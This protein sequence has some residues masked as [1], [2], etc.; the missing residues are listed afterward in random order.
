VSYARILPSA[1]L[2]TYRIFHNI[3][4]NNN[5]YV[6]VAI[7]SRVATYK[8]N[9]AQSMR[10]LIDTAVHTLRASLGDH[11]LKFR[12]RNYLHYTYYILVSYRS[13]ILRIERP[14][15]L[16]VREFGKLQSYIDLVNYSL[17]IGEC[18]A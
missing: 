10:P 1:V 12:L 5:L 2:Y 6:H 18:T 9:Y 17:I 7:T 13:I 16:K 4:I 14:S 15:E 3:F 11:E 8:S